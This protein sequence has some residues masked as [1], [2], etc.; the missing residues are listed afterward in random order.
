MR[1]MLTGAGGQVGVEMA[2][3]LA[4]RAEVAAFDRSALDLAD[5]DRIVERVRECRPDV[6]V[7]AAAYTAVDRAEQELEAARAANARAPGVL[8]AEAKRAGALLVHFST[9]YVFDGTK[10]APYVES[11]PTA[12]V[13][14]YGLTKREGEEAVAASGCDHLVLRTSWVYGPHGKN[15]MLTMLKLGATR[16]E[17]RVVNDQHGAPTSSR[18]I[19]AGVLR[20]L[21]GE[22]GVLEPASLERARAHG[23]LYHYTA[24]GATTWFDFARAIFAGWARRPGNAFTEPRVVAIPTSEFPTPARRPANSVLS[25]AKFE[26]AFGFALPPWERGLEEALSAVPA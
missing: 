12:P 4:G 10:A 3:C 9:D 20:L 19:A 5:P 2:R 7:N 8:A 15:F 14:A 25:N 6:I 21:G 1:V 26:S 24:A 11:D 23:G 22:A 17:L 18:Q 13:N 16:P